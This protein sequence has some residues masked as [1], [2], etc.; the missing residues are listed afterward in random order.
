MTS[1]DVSDKIHFINVDLDILSKAPLDVLVA[2]MGS[3]VSILYVGREGRLYGAHLEIRDLYQKDADALIRAFVALLRKLPRPARRLWNQ[4]TTRDFNIGVQ[5][6]P[7][8]RYHE[9]RIQSRTLE[10]VAA[11]GA[12]V[13]VT[14]YA[15]VEIPTVVKRKAARAR[16]GRTTRA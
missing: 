16:A 5:S 9:L 2:A 12:C 1:F 8:P 10:A 7:Q 11:L 6:A 13:V 14:T 3:K 15:P 4:A